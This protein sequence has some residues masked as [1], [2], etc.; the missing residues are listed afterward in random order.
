M[1]FTHK[2]IKYIGICVEYS[3]KLV[4]N[5][6]DLSSEST[7]NPNLGYL[8]I[9]K[10]KSDQKFKKVQKKLHVTLGRS[11]PN[12]NVLDS[13][14]RLKNDD[15]AKIYTVNLR[16]LKSQYQK[17]RL[18]E[19]CLEPLFGHRLRTKYHGFE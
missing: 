19:T 3:M 4:S 10:V 13:S 1:Q 15:S 12:L 7:L 18:L 14:V 2:S 5:E 16:H 11:H 17:V 9:R 6:V 8:H